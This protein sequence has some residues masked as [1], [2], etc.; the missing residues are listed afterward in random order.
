MR[1]IQDEI[2]SALA[3]GRN[4]YIHCR[5]GIGRTGLVAGCFLVEQGRD[6]ERALA[7]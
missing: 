1:R 5:A 4:V 2:A 6:G 7:S 3:A